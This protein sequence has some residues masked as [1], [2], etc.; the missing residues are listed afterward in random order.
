[1]P[2]NPRIPVLLDTD[3][4]YDI[5]DTWALALLLKSPEVDLKLVLSAT[6]NSVYAAKLLAKFLEA[7]GRPD[8][9]VG[10][11]LKFNDKVG[12]QS[13][14]VADYDL[15]SY[16]GQVYEDGVGALI[17]TIMSSPEPMT[18][19]CIA[20]L[21]NIGEALRREPR[22]AER[23]RFVGMHGSLRLGYD[24]SPELAKEYNVALHT[25]D[26]QRVFTAPWDMT[27]TPL[28]TCGLV[29]LT[30]DKYQKILASQDPMVQT[31]IEN[32]R[33]WCDWG[34]R[35]RDYWK[36]QSS[37]LFDTVAV[38]LTFCEELLHMERLGVRVT[39]D[40]C[41]VIDETAKKMDCATSWKDLA[42]FEDFL[43]ERLTG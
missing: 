13:P 30:G 35:E 23:A 3:I 10:V 12:G 11:G 32:Y 39:D 37:V 36:K 31:I 1:M 29:S 9:P 19:L 28:D 34:T 4:G 5:D 15:A 43:V 41:T 33:L 8:I 2:S 20:P 26:C 14:W 18:L 21:P 6:H 16:P 24:G 17:D 27:I 38:Y 25:P 42:A 40:G 7:A 22:L